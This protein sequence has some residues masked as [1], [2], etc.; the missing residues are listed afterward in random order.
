MAYC[1]ECK[2]EMNATDSVCPHCGHDFP[3]SS[4]AKKRQGIEYSALAD[5]A[6]IVG[7]VVAAINCVIAIVIM[8]ASIFERDYLKA[9]LYCPI[10]FLLSLA[11]L[12]VFLRI[13]KI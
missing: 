3:S 13:Q 11:M 12:V 5:L 10:G 6:L 2:G 4:D 7:G 9:F 8:L 1:P